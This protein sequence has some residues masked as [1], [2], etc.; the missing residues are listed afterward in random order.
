MKVLELTFVLLVVGLCCGERY[1][2]KTLVGEEFR[3]FHKHVVPFYENLFGEEMFDKIDQYIASRAEFW[4][5]TTVMIPMSDGVELKTIITFPHESTGQLSSVLDR[6]PYNADGVKFLIDTLFLP[7]NYI[8]IVQDLR[9]RY[10]SQGEWDFWRKSASDG[11]DTI[12]WIT[13]QEWSDGNVMSFGAS[14]DGIAATCQEGHRPPPPGL[15]AQSLLVATAD[16]YNSSYYNG[17]YRESLIGGWLE[18]IDE[19]SYIPTL[20][21]HE[22]YS[23]WW[24]PVDLSVQWNNTNVPAMHFG[25]WYDI[26]AE[27]TIQSFYG[28]Q[29]KGGEGALGNQYLVMDPLGHCPGGEYRFP[30][31]RNAWLLRITYDMF[32]QVRSGDSYQPQSLA[33]CFYVMSADPSTLSFTAPG[34]FW[35]CFNEMPEATNQDFYLH[36]DGSLTNTIPT[37]MESPE[38]SSYVYD[39]SYPVPTI[40]GN[41][42]NLPTCGPFDQTALETRDDVLVF[43]SEILSAP[44][45]ITGEVSVRLYVSSTANDT[46]FTAKLTDVYNGKSYNVIDGVI[47]MRW[48]DS[49]KE[50]S[51]MEPGMIYEVNFSLFTTSFLFQQGHQIRLDI[52]SSNYPRFSANMNNGMT[53]TEG[54]DPV[55]A[56]NTLYHSNKYRSVL[57][58]PVVPLS[59]LE[60]GAHNPFT[61]EEVIFAQ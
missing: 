46:D 34:N 20:K 5:S 32:E 41:N 14:A 23:P 6:T 54:G 43:T 52:S 48:R 29:Y 60:G 13:S 33:V 2:E 58:L 53:L 39:P 16:G 8:S 15:K 24:F 47:R 30:R 19:G 7:R 61:F 18:S 38:S 40:G 11:F 51:L 36:P 44:L 35:T 27:G 59:V 37:L 22:A 12:N 10:G 42:L 45:A 9:G 57:H 1:L 4:N 28:Y 3:E 55:V 21:E 49:N 50:I 31:G 17:A 25:G 56:T 26:F